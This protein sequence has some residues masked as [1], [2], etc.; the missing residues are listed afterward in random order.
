MKNMKSET[1][2]FVDVLFAR[3]QS[4]DMAYAAYTKRCGL[5]YI[6]ITVLEYL[7]DHPDGCTQKEIVAETFFPKQGVN[8]VI[9]DFLQ[10]GYVVLREME[11]DRRNKPVFLTE[12][13]RRYAEAIFAPI[14]EAVS[15]MAESL[16][17]EE[18]RG[19][20]K[21]LRLYDETFRKI[22]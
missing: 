22:I 7:S 5:T 9:K 2:N 12:K 14:Y 13:G 4:I 8:L 11:H 10:Q 21:A 17:S 1:E 3:M 6:G 20:L 19:F 15:D 18:R 16:S